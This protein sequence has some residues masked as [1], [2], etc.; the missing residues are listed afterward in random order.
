VLAAILMALFGGL[1]FWLGPPIGAAIVLKSRGFKT[2][3]RTA[4]AMVVLVPLIGLPIIFL[5]FR[6]IEATGIEGV[7]S[8]VLE[9]LLIALAITLAALAGRAFARWRQTGGL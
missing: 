6:V 3:W 2:P 5:S 1:G 4:L 9:L 7:I 8:I